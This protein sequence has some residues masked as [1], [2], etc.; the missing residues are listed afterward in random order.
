MST[1]LG[2]PV[3]FCIVLVQSKL[4]SSRALKNVTL[5]VALD[6][7]WARLIWNTLVFRTLPAVS[8]Q[9]RPLSGN[10][11]LWIY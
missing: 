8:V 5:R 10:M 3:N 1:S 9:M 11:G 6:K 4:S 2:Q 7:S